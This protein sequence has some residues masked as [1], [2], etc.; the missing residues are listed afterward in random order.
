M[1]G[2]EQGKEC[3]EKFAFSLHIYQTTHSL[4]FDEKLFRVL[5][6]NK[7][8]RSMK[9]SFLSK[10]ERFFVAKTATT[11]INYFKIAKK[12]YSRIMNFIK[13]FASRV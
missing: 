3:K 10:C 9:Q 13:Y 4:A 5:A 11:K 6:Y 12:F 8:A 1:D 7:N 2:N